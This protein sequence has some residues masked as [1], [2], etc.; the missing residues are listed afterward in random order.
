MAGVGASW[1][2]MGVLIGEG[3]EGEGGGR[4]GGVAVGVRHG[5]GRAAGGGC[6]DVAA[7]F[8]LLVARV[9][10]R[11][12]GNRKEEGEEKRKKRK[13][14]GKKEKEKKWKNFLNLEISKKK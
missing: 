1:P 4:E 3:R 2:A 6:L 10:V 9:A 11:E 12:E 7:W 8:S 13:R 5:E 14:E